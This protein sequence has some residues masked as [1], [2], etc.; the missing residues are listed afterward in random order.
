MVGPDQE[1]VRTGWFAAEPRRLV[2]TWRNWPTVH[3]AMPLFARAC[4]E[5]NWLSEVSPETVI[6]VHLLRRA[7]E[8][9][10]APPDPQTP[11]LLATPELHQAARLLDA[12]RPR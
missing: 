10:P 1:E 6:A 12:A 3:E 2:M 7:R 5:T 11:A 9:G 8:V 4:A